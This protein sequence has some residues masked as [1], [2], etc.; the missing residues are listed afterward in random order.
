MGTGYSSGLAPYT[1]DRTRTG[2]ELV[3]A[4]ESFIIS[5]MTLHPGR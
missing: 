1:Y 4:S 2:P 3:F 5:Q